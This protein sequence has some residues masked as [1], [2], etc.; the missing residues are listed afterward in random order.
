[1]DIGNFSKRTILTGAGWSRTWGGRLA[2]EVWEDLIGHQNIQ[3]NGF[4][5][6]YGE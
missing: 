4:A 2:Q 5:T 1:M 3:G 6:S